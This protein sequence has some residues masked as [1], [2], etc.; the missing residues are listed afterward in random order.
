M[1]DDRDNTSFAAGATRRKLAR[2]QGGAAAAGLDREEATETLRARKR[3]D[4]G[5]A[6]A[7]NPNAGRG[8]QSLNKPGERTR[9]RAYKAG[10]K[11]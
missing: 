1:Q 5:T 2:R 10:K 8:R 9:S 11:K 7:T 6:G 3:A 4:G